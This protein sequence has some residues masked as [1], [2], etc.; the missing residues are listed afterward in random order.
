MNE[1][2]RILSFGLQESLFWS[3]VL[4]RRGE[5]SRLLLLRNC[6]VGDNVDVIDRGCFCSGEEPVTPHW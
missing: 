1:L 4:R 3:V 6:D 2:R 5:H